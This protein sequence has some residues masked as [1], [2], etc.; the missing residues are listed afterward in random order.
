MYVHTATLCGRLLQ[1]GHLAVVSDEHDAVSG[2]NWRR[3]EVAA[4]Y[5]H[6]VP[7]TAS[8]TRDT[9]ENSK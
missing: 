7:P 6:H 3:T 9:V 2:I 4:L 5:S 8:P 1:C